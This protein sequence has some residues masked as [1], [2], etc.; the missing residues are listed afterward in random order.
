VRGVGAGSKA[1]CRT[2]HAAQQAQQG[3]HFWRRQI[4]REPPFGRC[5]SFS[6]CLKLCLA[7]T[8]Q[9]EPKSPTILVDHA[10]DQPVFFKLADRSHQ[11][12]WSGPDRRRQF[13]LR[14]HGMSRDGFQ[15]R[16]LDRCEILPLECSFEAA[17]SSEMRETKTM[18]D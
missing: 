13:I 2:G 17:Y 4:L 7:G 18:P 14:L 11:N 8:G 10:T 6:S 5:D 12:G 16:E 9:G 15:D 1:L 3:R